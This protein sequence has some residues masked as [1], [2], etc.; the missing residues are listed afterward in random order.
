MGILLR[1]M[2]IQTVELIASGVGYRA[3]FLRS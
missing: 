3:D 1:T 2:G